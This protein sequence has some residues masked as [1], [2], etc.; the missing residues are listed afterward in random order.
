MTVNFAK[1]RN[2]ESDIS[3]TSQRQKDD[4]RVLH[5]GANNDVLVRLDGHICHLSTQGRTRL[6][7][8]KSQTWCMRSAGM[9]GVVQVNGT[10]ECIAAGS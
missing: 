10:E 3:N 9:T 6:Q 1:G 2:V 8:Q 4:T 5:G 7:L